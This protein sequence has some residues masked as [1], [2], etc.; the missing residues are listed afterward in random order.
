VGRWS[1][2]QAGMWGLG[3]WAAE[4]LWP[5]ALGWPELEFVSVPALRLARSPPGNCKRSVKSIKGVSPDI[6]KAFFYP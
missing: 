3:W 6:L 4:W 2:G 5:L 1:V